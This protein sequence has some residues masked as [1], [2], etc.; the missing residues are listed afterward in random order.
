VESS[1]CAITIGGEKFASGAILASA[2]AAILL[3][4]YND[5]KTNERQQWQ[6]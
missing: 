2:R 6:N 1:F 3:E 5:K 4:N